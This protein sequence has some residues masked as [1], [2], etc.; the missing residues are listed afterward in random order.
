MYIFFCKQ[1]QTHKK[2]VSLYLQ[3]SMILSTS[4][5]LPPNKPSAINLI[6]YKSSVETF[7]SE[8]E[9]FLSDL[10]TCSFAGTCD[11]ASIF[12]MF[13]KGAKDD[14]IAAL[15]D[16]QLKKTIDAAKF[17]MVL[18]DGFAPARCNYILP[19]RHGLPY[20]SLTDPYE[21]WFLRIPAVPSFV[22]IQPSG[23]TERM[24]FR[25]RLVSLLFHIGI[26]TASIP[27]GHDYL[28]EKY[29]P[30]LP[31]KTVHELARDS[32]VFFITKDVVLDYPLP[33]LPHVINIGGI[34]V[35]PGKP[36]PQDLEQF[37]KGAEHGVI[38]VS[39]GTVA[40]YFP[41]NLNDRMY[42]AFKQTKLRVLWRYTGAKYENVPSH[43]K[44]MDWIPQND[45]LAHPK[46]KVFITH[47]GNNGQYEGLYH[48]VPMLGMPITGGDQPYN[49]KRA[50]YKGIGVW[51][52]TKSFTS[53]DLINGI[54]ELTENRTYAQ[55]IRKLSTIYRSQA[56]NA[57]DTV[58]FWLEHLTKFG[59]SHLRSYALD[60]PWYQYLML[61]IFA[62]ILV[63][64]HIIVYI[65]TRIFTYLL[66]KCFGSKP[67]K[68]K[69][70]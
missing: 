55:N 5:S 45:I 65:V 37:M 54:K 66:A 62:L 23:M 38:V 19:Y 15:E 8:T 14:C 24:S 20:A 21:P 18:V 39:F 29:A 69:K 49:A 42:E 31:A 70:N 10:I 17:D 43:I 50:A 53:T 35:K 26:G 64:L 34:S 46:T 7:V 57:Q 68:V 25:E 47:C 27:A 33:T 61:D 44:L 32:M 12:G 2:T 60:M 52:D 4:V 13:S 48:G 11:T 58:S 51:V 30:S 41:Q 22:P 59:G 63:I 56:M 1:T 16:P 67:K 28:V 9:E 6:T 3:V 40:K 36:L